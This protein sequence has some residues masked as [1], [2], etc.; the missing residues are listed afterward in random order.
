MLDFIIEGSMTMLD[1]QDLS[2]AWQGKQVVHHVSFHL[3]KGGVLA[4]VGESGSGK[5]TILKAI[6]GLP[7]DERTVTGGSILLDGDDL[8]QKNC[9]RAAGARWPHALDDLPG[10]G[11][12]VLPR[13]PRR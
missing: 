6:L 4:I 10:R 9:G 5:S 8:L 13:A 3:P 11:R 1:V 2:V 12:V 7:S